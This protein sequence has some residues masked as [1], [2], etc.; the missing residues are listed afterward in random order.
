MKHRRF[1]V[2]A[3]AIAALAGLSLLAGPVYAKTVNS[4]I[5]PAD[6]VPP[7]AQPVKLPPI[8]VARVDKSEQRMRVSTARRDYI[9]PTG[10]W[11]PKRIHKMRPGEQS[12]ALKVRPE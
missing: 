2:L 11:R 6:S 7:L 4:G 3:G 10:S 1:S 12:D 5:F 8:V 9:T